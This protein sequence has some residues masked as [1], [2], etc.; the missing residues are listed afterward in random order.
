MLCQREYDSS[1]QKNQ[2]YPLCDERERERE[3]DRERETVKKRRENI[4]N[5]GKGQLFEKTKRWKEM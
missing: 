2:K 1:Y 5:N 4:L 3:R